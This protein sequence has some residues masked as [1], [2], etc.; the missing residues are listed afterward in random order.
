M[1]GLMENN[2]LLVCT[3]SNEK[4]LPRLE[5][6]LTRCQVEI[7]EMHTHDWLEKAPPEWL[8]HFDAILLDVPC[9]KAGV[10]RYRV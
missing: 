10:L 4:R 3:D 2:G 7:A 9:S 1:A 6:N 5:E 8:N